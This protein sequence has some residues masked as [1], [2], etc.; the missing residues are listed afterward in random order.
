MRVSFFSL[1][2]VMSSLGVFAQVG[3]PVIMTINNKN[4][5]KSE[6]EYFYNKYNNEDIIDKRSLKDY[7]DSF[8]DF[9]LKVIEAESLGMDTTSAFITELSGYRSSE[10]KSYMDELKV[11]DELARKEYDRMKNMIEVSHILIAFPGVTNN[12][13]KTVPADTLEPYKKAVQVRNRIIKGEKFEKV[14]AELSDD[15]STRNSERPGYLGWLSGLMFNLSFAPFEDAIYNTPAGK[16]GELVRSNLGYH[17]IKV[18]SKKANQGQINAAHILILCPSGSDTVKIDDARKKIDSIYNEIINGADFSALARENSQDPGSASRGGELGWFGYGMMVKEFQDAAF[19]LKDSGDISKPFRTQ[20]GFHI[21]KLLGKKP[22]EPFEE[23]RKE[24]EERLT[25][26]GFFIPLHQQAIDDMKKEYGFQKNE[27]GYRALF[28][29]ANTVYPTDSSFYN[30]FETQ[31]VLLFT[32]GNTPYNSK[33]FIDFLKKNIRS[34]FTM[35]TDLLN[36]RLQDFEYNSLLAA[37]D[38]SLESKYPDFRNLMQELHDGILM[39]EI[40]TKEVFG[41]ADEKEG[42]STFFEKNKQNYAFTEPY[43]KGYVVLVKDAKIKKQIQKETALME[44]E[45]A[46]QYMYDAYKVGDVSYVKVDKGLFKKGDNSFVDESAF[47]S[48]VATYPDGFKDFFL[49]GKV[50]HAPETYMDVR[51]QVVTDYQDYLEKVWL[52]KLNDKY[53]TTIYTD[54]LNTIK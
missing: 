22:F 17:I 39:Y 47:K 49:I 14:A 21:I 36:D 38:K 20:F 45:Q 1:L 18:H 43:F 35:S 7:I 52:Q 46:V 37:K 6:F 33:Q 13:L 3:D 11:N 34:P 12:Q 28:D 25:A 15:P 32:A 19:A 16:I 40:S 30:F 4:F 42:L 50:I 8:R 23:K 31:P 26:G 10:A 44:P 54:V 24:I 48:G 9:K 51:G 27:A 53:R 2:L 29:K 5:K 41:K